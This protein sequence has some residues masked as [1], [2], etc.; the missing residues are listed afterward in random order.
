MEKEFY[1]R[2]G[3]SIDRLVASQWKNAAPWRGTL[4]SDDINTSWCAWHATQTRQQS[5]EG[6]KKKLGVERMPQSK[7]RTETWAKIMNRR[8]RAA[9]LS[10]HCRRY[11]CKAAATA[12]KKK[13]RKAVNS[14]GQAHPPICSRT[15]GIKAKKEEKRV[16]QKRRAGRQEPKTRLMINVS[17]ASRLQTKHNQ[18][19]EKLDVLATH[20]GW[21]KKE[22]RRTD[23]FYAT[24]RRN[25]YGTYRRSSDDSE[26]KT[27]GGSSVRSLPCRNL[28]GSNE[29]KPSVARGW[30]V[31]LHRMSLAACYGLGERHW[32]ADESW[33][34]NRQYI[35]T[36]Q[37]NRQQRI[38][39]IHKQ[40]QWEQRSPLSLSSGKKKGGG[41]HSTLSSKQ[42]R[43][44]FLFSQARTGNSV[45]TTSRRCRPAALLGHFHSEA[46]KSNNGWK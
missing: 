31:V 41:F 39:S 19:H 12:T 35:T 29:W 10:G 21:E 20:S 16:K 23:S 46:C 18:H 42:E 27:P 43:A 24:R 44:F 9:V 5:K 17:P 25:I 38:I 7:V 33:I 34:Q 6:K 13:W 1:S 28:K 30:T 11:L 14:R 2:S 8:C 36:R 4:F 15:N 40:R 32:R 26:S 37:K 45:E 3:G 22:S